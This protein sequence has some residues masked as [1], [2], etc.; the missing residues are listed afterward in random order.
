MPAILARLCAQLLE[1]SDL[2]LLLR[3]A[4]LLLLI[5]S[6]VSGAGPG[7]ANAVATAAAS[8]RSRHKE[9]QRSVQAIS[10]RTNES[11]KATG[12]KKRRIK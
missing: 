11:P 8:R 6:L 1:A 5:T 7:P 2:M 12:S 9:A 3:L 4:L 10:G